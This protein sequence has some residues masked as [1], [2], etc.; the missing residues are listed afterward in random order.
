MRFTARQ[1]P[2]S[3]AVALDARLCKIIR[4]R[5]RIQSL[6]ITIQPKIS[7]IWCGPP[8]RQTTNRQCRG[9]AP[10]WSVTV[11]SSRSISGREVP[12]TALR[13]VGR[14]YRWVAV[15]LSRKEARVTY[16][17]PI[18]MMS[19]AYKSEELWASWI[20]S[21]LT[22]SPIYKLLA[23]AWTIDRPWICPILSS[24]Y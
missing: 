23:L 11:A 17:M 6:E 12:F 8:L 3:M 13:R 21:H 10:L 18:N 16:S 19:R 15:L 7:W 20:R 22:H 5:A 24:I 9:L 1:Q 14:M 4:G 2:V